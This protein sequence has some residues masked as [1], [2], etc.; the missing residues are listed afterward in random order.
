VSFIFAE[1]DDHGFSCFMISGGDTLGRSRKSMLRLPGFIGFSRQ[2]GSC[3]S[4][5][6]PTFP[7]CQVKSLSAIC[8]RI[9]LTLFLIFDTIFFMEVNHVFYKTKS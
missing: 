1:R 9:C 3:D 4:L 5:I 7:I 6:N 8:K 2:T